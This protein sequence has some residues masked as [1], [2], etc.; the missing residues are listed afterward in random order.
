MTRGGGSVEPNFNY[1]VISR[2]VAKEWFIKTELERRT[3]LSLLGTAILETDWSCLAYAVMSSHIHLLLL[4]GNDTLAEWMRPMHTAFANWINRERGREGP[5]FIKGP[6]VKF[7]PQDDVARVMNYIHYNPVRA[8]VVSAPEGSKWTSY[9]AYLRTERAPTWLDVD[10]GSS[11]I[12]S[13]TSN[14]FEAW[15]RTHQVQRD[16]MIARGF[17]PRVTRGRPPNTPA[18]FEATS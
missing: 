11:L 14:E 2:F 16:E 7:V 18:S 6:N 12:G 13:M 3:Y 1:H 8:G 4:S 15:S 9:R 5:V 17:V 10:R